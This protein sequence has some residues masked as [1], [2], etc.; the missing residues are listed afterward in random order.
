MFQ[1]DCVVF[2]AQQMISIKGLPRPISLADVLSDLFPL[3]ALKKG[4]MPPSKNSDLGALSALVLIG[5]CLCDL[6]DA[7]MKWSSLVERKNLGKLQLR[8]RRLVAELQLSIRQSCS[9]LRGFDEERLVQ[10][11]F[12]SVS[13]NVFSFMLSV[14]SLEILRIKTAVEVCLDSFYYII[15]FFL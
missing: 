13:E 15:A 14:I 6:K 11:M 4:T 5:E 2:G 1:R 8:E 7:V 9:V 10:L 3:D 12:D